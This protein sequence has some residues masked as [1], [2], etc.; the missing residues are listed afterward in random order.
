MHDMVESLSLGGGAVV[1]AVL[2]FFL[3]LAWA[4]VP[5]CKLRWLGAIVTPSVLAYCLYW[6]PV[7]TGSDASEYSVWFLICFVPWFLSG[8]AVSAG[9]LFMLRRH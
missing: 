6:Y 3:A 7:W 9:V 1:I 2:S 8:A 4:F 5:S